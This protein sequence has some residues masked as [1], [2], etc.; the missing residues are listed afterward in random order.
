MTVLSRL[1][2]LIVLSVAMS[3]CG[4]SLPPAAATLA[5]RDA[6]LAP[7]AAQHLYVAND[8]DTVTVYATNSSAL[9]RKIDK[10]VANVTATGVDRSGNFY[11]ANGGTGIEIAP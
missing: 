2:A 1:T 7:Q 6:V 3:A 10:G 11:I 5:Q 8:N 9:V 4:R